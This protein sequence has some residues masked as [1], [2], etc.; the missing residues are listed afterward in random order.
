MSQT[1]I[2]TLP[3]SIQV[4][5]WRRTIGPEH[6]IDAIRRLEKGEQSMTYAIMLGLL[7]LV[8]LQLVIM[9]EKLKKTVTKVLRCV[10]GLPQSYWNGLNQKL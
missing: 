1:K 9:P 5:T 6:K 10:V 4:K 8:Y 7:I 2:S 3:T